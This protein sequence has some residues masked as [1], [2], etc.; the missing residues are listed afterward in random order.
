MTP[1][2]NETHHGPLKDGE[3][4]LAPARKFG[5]PIADLVGPMPYTARQTLIDVPNAEHGLHRYWR[6]AFTE[7]I[8]DELIDALVE[9]AANFSSP[10]SALIYRLGSGTLDPSSA[11]SAR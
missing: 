9:G 5:T 6:S 8:S 10:L 1:L 7:E 11:A 3:E 4:V 2:P